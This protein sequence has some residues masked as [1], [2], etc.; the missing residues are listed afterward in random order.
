MSGRMNAVERRIQS[1]LG[2][3]HDREPRRRWTDGEW[4]REVKHAVGGTG[5]TLGYKIYANRCRFKRNGEWL[6]DLVWLRQGSGGELLDAPL[7]LE[8]EWRRAGISDDFQKL[9][10]ARARHRVMVFQARNKTRAVDIIEKLVAQVEVCKLT[11]PGD[12]YLFACWLNAGRD[13]FFHLH[14][15]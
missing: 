2:T 15:T 10:V 6:F 9:L 5:E 8:S 4:T 13:F 7:V 3:L 14:V 11:E 1:A 12:R